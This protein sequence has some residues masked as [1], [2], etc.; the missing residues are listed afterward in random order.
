MLVSHGVFSEWE[1]ISDILSGI[2]PIYKLDKF[3]CYGLN[4]F[5]LQIH[6]LKTH[7]PV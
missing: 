5:S 1:L 2:D 4:C 7:P 6:M 3:L